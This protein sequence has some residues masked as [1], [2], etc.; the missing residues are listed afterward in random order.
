VIAWALT[1]VLHSTL[2]VV[3]AA[4]LVRLPWARAAQARDAI[5]KCALVGGLLTATLQQ[6]IGGPSLVVPVR[7]EDSRPALDSAV[8]A[9]VDGNQRRMLG[10]LSWLALAWAVTSGLAALRLGRGWRQVRRAAGRRRVLTGGPLR[11][12]LDAILREAGVTRRV[13]LSCSRGLVVPRAIGTREI[14]VP[15]R[16]LRELSAPEQR[17]LLAHETAHLLRYDGAWLFAAAV[18]QTVAW[19]QPLTRLAA[20][21]LRHSMEWCCDDWAAARLPDRMALAECLVKVGE[22]GVFAPRG[23]ALAAFAGSALRERVERLIDAD[24]VEGRAA[25][26]SWPAAVLLLAVLALAPRVTLA[27]AAAAASPAAAPTDATVVSAEAAVPAVDPRPVAAG[28]RSAARPLPRVQAAPPPLPGATGVS[29]DVSWIGV[30]VQT[31]PASEAPPE[32]TLPIHIP[33]PLLQSSP[34]SSSTGLMRAVTAAARAVPP[35][36]APQPLIGK[37]DLSGRVGRWLEFTRRTPSFDP[38][39]PKY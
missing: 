10:G 2:L 37:D 32:M 23:V 34:A 5:W 7:V 13:T 39:H 19:W 18:L 15:M 4:A 31:T 9:A 1:Y 35:R 24:R 21:R 17:A 20:A 12:E 14:C 26:R 25:R 3:A 28:R 27:V 22:W 30:P 36:T 11:R 38:L 16:V 8:S 6:A 29:R 33:E